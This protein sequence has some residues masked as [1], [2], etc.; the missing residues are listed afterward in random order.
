M[1]IKTVRMIMCAALSAAL[2]TFGPGA[3]ATQYG[4][5]FDPPFTVPGLMVIDVPL[6]S[7]CRDGGFQPTCVF[8]V[9]SVDFTDTVGNEW[10]IPGPETPGGTAVLFDNLGI[11]LLDIQV[12]ISDLILI[13]DGGAECGQIGPSLTI[14]IQGD[15]TFT[16]GGLVNTGNVLSITEIPEPATLALLG[17]G[18]SGLALR[19]RRTLN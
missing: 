6:G 16:C 11:T 18:M 19:R 10:G 7:P 2:G 5:V 15:V 4:V 8:Q 3:Q 1:G 17:L 14:G 12:T 9:L 13:S